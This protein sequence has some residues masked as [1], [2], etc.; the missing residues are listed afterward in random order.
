[1]GHIY[2]VYF[3]GYFQGVVSICEFK[4]MFCVG[5]GGGN[6]WLGLDWVGALNM[7][8]MLSLKAMH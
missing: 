5:W 4:R 2:C 8:S 3:L 7:Q 1:M 6:W